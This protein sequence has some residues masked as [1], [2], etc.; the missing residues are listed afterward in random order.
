MKDRTSIRTS[1]APV[2]AAIPTMTMM[3]MAMRTR[4]SQA[5][6]ASIAKGKLE[7]FNLYLPGTK[8]Q[9]AETRW[10]KSS[11]SL[12]AS[13]P[14]G[15]SAGRW[16]QRPCQDARSCSEEPRGQSA[17]EATASVAPAPIRL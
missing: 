13:S 2:A 3:K 17:L 4:C 6:P 1:A 8:R 12:A 11:L 10:T 5:G 7:T 16:Y 15:R 9:G 14:V